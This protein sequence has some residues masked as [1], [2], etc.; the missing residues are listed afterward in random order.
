MFWKANDD[1]FI[2]Q[3]LSLAVEALE[4]GATLKRFLLICIVGNISVWLFATIFANF[5]NERFM[6]VFNV[7]NKV[8]AMILGVPFGF[9]MWIT[10]SL[11]RLKMPNLEDNKAL[12][13][14]MMSSFT[15]QRDSTRRWTVWLFAIIVGV[16][17]VFGLIFVN[18]YLSDQL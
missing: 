11:C 14:E 13:S 18:L 3:K 7:S 17:N 2:N 4:N 9:A 15:Y 1:S 5:A 10:Y 16:L 8:G 6:S 12:N